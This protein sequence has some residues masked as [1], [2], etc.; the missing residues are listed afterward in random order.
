MRNLGPRSR[1]WLARQGV[2]DLDGLRRHDPFRLYARLLAGGV[3]ANLNL[4]YALIGAIEDRDWR[5]VQRSDRSSILLRLDD[6]GL[7][8]R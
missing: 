3:P 5:E 8:P 4:L 2:H 6:M 1:T 7:A